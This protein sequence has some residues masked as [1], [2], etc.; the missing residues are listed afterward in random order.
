[1]K[2]PPPR[3]ACCCARR[4]EVDRARECSRYGVILGTLGRQGNPAILQRLEEQLV[5]K[6]KEYTVVLLS[7]IMPGKARGCCACCAAGAARSAQRGGHPWL[8]AH[9]VCAAAADPL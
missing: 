8:Q 3:H 5:A 6:G 9:R 7:E 1:M 4:R 2:T